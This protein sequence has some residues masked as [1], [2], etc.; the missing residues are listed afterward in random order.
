MNSIQRKRQQKNLTQAELGKR[1]GV[2][3]NTVAQ[4]ESGARKPSIIM[5]KRIAEVFHCTTD[6]LL[7]GIPTPK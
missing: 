2:N 3:Q 1:V 5:L 4:W 6:E 7:E